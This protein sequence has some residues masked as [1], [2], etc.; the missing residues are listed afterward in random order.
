MFELTDQDILCEDGA[1]IA[2]NKPHGVITQ[3]APRGVDSLVDLVKNYLKQ[4]YQKPGNVYLGVPHRIDRPVSGIVVFSR[5]S[6]CAARLSE[7]FAKR[8]VQKIYHAVLERPPAEREGQLEDW[9]YRIPDHSRVEISSQSNTEAKYAQLSYKTLAVHQGR[10]L[11]EVTLGTGRMHQIRIQFA[12]RG[13]PIVGDEQYGSR[14]MFPGFFSG[15][16]LV[17]PIA[18]HARR[19]TLQHPIRY[20]PLTIIAPLPAMWKRLGFSDEVSTRFQ[21]G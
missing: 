11:V 13:C 5:N 18:L 20:E 9:I 16:R 3:G 21:G 15:E 14:G 4:K 17:A 19:L 10:A 1:V 2:V 7:Q 8:Q 12:S 6:K